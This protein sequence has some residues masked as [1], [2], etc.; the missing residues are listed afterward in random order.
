MLVEPDKVKYS[1]MLRSDRSGLRGSRFLNIPGIQQTVTVPAGHI[2]ING[3]AGAKQFRM[4]VGIALTGA[5]ARE[6]P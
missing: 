6:L 4:S 3:R 2:G 1:A 5:G